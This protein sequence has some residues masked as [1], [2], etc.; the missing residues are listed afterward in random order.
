[1]SLIH[2]VF[3]TDKHFS[4]N[5]STRELTNQT[6]E[7]TQLMQGDHNSERISFNMPRY[8]EG[9]DMT[10]CNV[11]Q[12]HYT[13]IDTKTKEEVPGLYDVIDVQ[14]SPEDENTAIFTWLVSANATGL[15][16]SLQFRITFK[17][18]KD[19][20]DVYR[21][22]TEICKELKVSKGI[23]NSEC[24]DEDCA[25]FVSGWEERIKKLEAKET[26][27]FVAVYGSTTF[28]AIGDAANA[29]M[30]CVA[31]RSNAYRAVLVNNNADVKKFFR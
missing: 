28:K 10:L 3:D 27:T 30:I 29:G 14:T 18:V 2:N 6:P 25:D 31:S 9:H 8:V 20:I 21:W 24:F 23:T 16:G 7:K 1:M 13:N 12:V 11:I 5:V 15:V 4:I 26:Q 19:G 22:N 17:C